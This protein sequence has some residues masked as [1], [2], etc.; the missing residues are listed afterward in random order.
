MRPSAHSVLCSVLCAFFERPKSC[1][2]HVLFLC[3]NPH[4]VW[5]FG[6]VVWLA[7]PYGWLSHMADWVV[8]LAEP[9]GWLS[10]MAG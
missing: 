3:F 5:L 4:P 7:E 8:W 10:H 1:A 6:W 9:Y 2:L